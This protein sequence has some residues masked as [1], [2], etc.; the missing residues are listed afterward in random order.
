MLEQ[1]R[2][3]VEFAQGVC[4]A[5]AVIASHDAE[6]VWREVVIANGGYDYL[7]GVSRRSGN[8]RIDGFARYRKDLGHAR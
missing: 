7:H 6:V 8:L 3:R 4:A 5:L 1:S 2:K